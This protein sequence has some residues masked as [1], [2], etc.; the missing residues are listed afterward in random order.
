M[1]ERKKWIEQK[2]NITNK[3]FNVRCSVFTFTR[4]GVE[5]IHVGE[6]KNNGAIWRWE[7]E[8]S[9]F[10]LY[11]LFIHTQWWREL[12]AVYNTKYTD[13]FCLQLPFSLAPSP[14]R[15]HTFIR[16]FLFRSS[17]LSV[18]SAVRWGSQEHQKILH[19]SH[20]VDTHHQ[21][22]R[23]ENRPNRFV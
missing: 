2:S 14:T 4:T 8:D 21:R 9:G 7:I 17:L 16:C 5:K 3:M 22:K 20:I 23:H 19:I 18:C 6:R 13:W 12:V 15:V 10:Y 11:F 1:N